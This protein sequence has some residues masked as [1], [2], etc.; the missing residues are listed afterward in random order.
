MELCRVEG[1]GADCWLLAGNAE[2]PRL[3][4]LVEYT[5]AAGIHAS[6]ATNIQQ[7]TQGSAFGA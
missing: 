2:R 6:T 1:Q 4:E 7:F 3:W 5:G